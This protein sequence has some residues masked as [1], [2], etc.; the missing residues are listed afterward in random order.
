MDIEIRL[1]RPEDAPGIRDVFRAA[2]GEEYFCREV[3]DL[4]ALRGWIA[5]ADDLVFVAVRPAGSVVG[6]AMVSVRGRSRD[7][8]VGEFGR[9]CVR[10]S[11]SGL[12]LGTRLMRARLRAADRRL[13]LG[14]SETR[15]AVPASTAIGLRHGFRPVG[16]LPSKDRFA[17]RES[18]ILMA[19]PFGGALAAR[20]P[21]PRL[22]P[23]A[24]PVARLALR[25]LGL[26]G[27]VAVVAATEVGAPGGEGGVEVVPVAGPASGEVL[28]AHR[29]GRTAG[30]LAWRW[31][32][33]HRRAVL[34]TLRAADDAVRH[35]LLAAVVEEA[36]GRGALYLEAD[37]GT[38]D[39][40]AQ[41]SLVVLGFRAG[42]FLPAVAPGPS[43]RQDLVRMIRVHPAADLGPLDLHPAA[44]PI[45]AAVL[46]GSGTT[47]AGSP[48]TPS[49]DRS[50]SGSVPVR[51]ARAGRADRRARPPRPISSCAPG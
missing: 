28:V 4:V 26:P 45:A 47:V 33:R 17:T 19:R 10:P 50:T 38:A 9:L 18:S 12:G 22:V 39:P 6:T 36:E 40:A 41:R 16:F 2:Y 5:G 8:G 3:Y 42:G 49:G 34:G 14:L 25:A 51:P 23:E 43:G 29:R 11:A 15:A 13:R 37:V 7:S 30:R 1:A 46:D 32:R 24:A 35:A 31:S 27:D 48:P 44:R 20:R 21:A